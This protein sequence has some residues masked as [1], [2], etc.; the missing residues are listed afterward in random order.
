[1]QILDALWIWVPRKYNLHEYYD[2]VCYH[3]FWL[4]SFISPKVSK[5]NFPINSIFQVC[6]IVSIFKEGFATKNLVKEVIESLNL[7]VSNFK[8]VSKSTVYEYNKGDI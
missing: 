3:I 2:R 4:S 5:I 7:D 1:M 8:C 6:G